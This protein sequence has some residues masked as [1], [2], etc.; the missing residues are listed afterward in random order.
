MNSDSSEDIL[1]AFATEP[2]HDPATL[3]RYLRAHPELTDDLI[4]LSRE[5]SR[6][7]EVRHTPLTPKED[8]YREAAW[9][10]HVLAV[11]DTEDRLAT[12]TVER[13]REVCRAIDIPRQVLSSLREHQVLVA[14]IPRAFL[15]QLAAVIRWTP[16]ALTE[17][18]SRPSLA[19]ARN[20]KSEEKPIPATQVS[21][22]ELMRQSCATEAQLAKWQFDK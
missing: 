7:R 5:L 10:K 8:S 3:Q 12:L 2:N 21:F 18:L 20:Y 11:P 6:E 4:D 9:R 15:E 14:S 16:D 19:Y 22:E 13:Q 17:S 1:D